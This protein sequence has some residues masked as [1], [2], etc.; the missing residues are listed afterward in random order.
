MY[1]FDGDGLKDLMTGKRWWSHGRSEPG[2]EKPAMIYWFKCSKAKDGVLTFTPQ[3]IDDD[4]GIGTQFE[5]ID[6][7]KDGLPD[8]VVS[9]KKGVH[10]LT[11]VR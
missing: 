6:I 7:D 2:S 3:A 5:V 8:I 4:S 10:L 11:Q 9:N 1:D